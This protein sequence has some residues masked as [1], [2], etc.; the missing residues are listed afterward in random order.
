[1]GIGIFA[2]VHQGITLLVDGTRSAFYP[3]LYLDA[4]GEEDHGLRRGKP[5]YLSAARQ[6]AIHRLWL[7]QAVPREVARSRASAS[8]A[9]IRLGLY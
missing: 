1:M 2:L 6:E 8:H 5:L 4:H 3:S 9:A 7:A